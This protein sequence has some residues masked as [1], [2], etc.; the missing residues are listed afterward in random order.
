MR[1]YLNCGSFW[2]VIEDVEYNNLEPDVGF[3]KII[4]LLLSANG[5]YFIH[6]NELI[7][8]ENYDYMDYKYSSSIIGSSDDQLR[9]E[10][11]DVLLSKINDERYAIQLFVKN[12]NSYFKDYDPICLKLFFENYLCEYKVRKISKINSISNSTYYDYIDCAEYLFKRA[13]CLY[14][15]NKGML[16]M[17]SD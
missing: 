17:S 7:F 3:M 6:C 13:F 8:V 4:K 2:K 5:T 15:P 14:T 9:I 10:K 11:A 1:K 16:E 12:I